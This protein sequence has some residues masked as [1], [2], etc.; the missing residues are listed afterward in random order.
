MSSFFRRR[1][2]WRINGG[3]CPYV[4]LLSIPFLSGKGGEVSYFFSGY[5]RLSSVI[6]SRT[7]VRNLRD[8]QRAIGR[9]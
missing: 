3:I 1:L 2:L 7:S 8:S 4:L 6:L 9:S 5:F